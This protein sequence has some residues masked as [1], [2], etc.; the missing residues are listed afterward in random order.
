MRFRVAGYLGVVWI[1][2]KRA[3]VGV[4]AFAHVLARVVRCPV[5]GHV[6]V[7]AAEYIQPRIHVVY[8]NLPWAKSCNED[9]WGGRFW[10]PWGGLAGGWCFRL[11]GFRGAADPSVWAMVSGC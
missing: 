10:Q 6:G 4:L 8:A 1:W 5:S 11:P 2:S 3:Y 9:P 7:F